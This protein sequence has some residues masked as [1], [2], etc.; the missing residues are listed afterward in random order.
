MTHAEQQPVDTATFRQPG[1]GAVKTQ[2]APA[3]LLAL[4][5][6]VAPR[7]PAFIR[8]EGLDRGFLRGEPGGQPGSG[9]RRGSCLAIR[10][11][12]RGEEAPDVTL[13]EPRDCG[14]DVRNSYDID[15]D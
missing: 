14:R 11:L 6:D 12:V 8:I 10:R 13:A 1:R 9:D 15:A 7:R 5:F 2:R 3:R 4:H